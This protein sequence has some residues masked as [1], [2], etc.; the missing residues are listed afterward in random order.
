M[1]K[2]K[3]L[4]LV[5]SHRSD[6]TPPPTESCFNT[7][8]YYFKNEHIL[9]NDECASSPCDVNA[10]CTNTPGSFTCKCN[11]GYSGDGFNCVGM[12]NSFTFTKK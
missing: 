9:D 12:Q 2:F 6:C 8:S 7:N 4:I 11:S 3:T 5:S 10:R 1:S